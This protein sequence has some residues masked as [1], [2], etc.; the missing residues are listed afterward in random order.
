MGLFSPKKIISVASSVYNMAGE[1]KDRPQYLQSLFVRNILSETKDTI[2]QTINN[3]YATNSPGLKLRQFFKW[4][5]RKPETYNKIGIPNGV[6]T[7]GN[8]IDP[9]EL[10]PYIPHSP[11]QEVWVQS[12]SIGN[13]DPTY[14]AEQWIFINRPADIDTNWV[15]EYFKDS[16]TITIRFVDTSIVSIPATGF[17]YEAKYIYAYYMLVSS[18]TQG[19]IVPGSLVHIGE[20]PF[21][22]TTEWSL[23]SSTFAPITVTLETTTVISTHTLKHYSDGRPDEST[24]VDGPP[25]TSTSSTSYDKGEQV[26]SN[27]IYYGGDADLTTENQWMYQFQDASV[28]MTPTSTSAPPVITTEVVD[29]VTITTTV[30]VTTNVETDHIVYDRSYRIDTQTVVNKSYTDMQLMIYQIGSGNAA[31][32][33]LV[34]VVGQYEEFYP[35]IPIRLKSDWL[36]EVNPE[37]YEQARKA[38]KKATGSKIESLIEDLK[39]NE[40]I[41]DIDNIYTVFGVALNVEEEASRRYVYA[42]FEK[43]QISQ[44]G[45]PLAY[46]VFKAKYQNTIN[47]AQ[48]WY[49]WKARNRFDHGGHDEGQDSDPEPPRFHYPEPPVNEIRVK[50][51]SSFDSQ[52]DIR[53]EWAFISN[54]TGTGQGQP[55]AKANDCWIQYMGED[56]FVKVIYLN[57]SAPADH[58]YTYEK[59]RIYW[60]RSANTFTWLEIV[61][62]KHRN[63]VYGG[64][65]VSISAKEALEDS[66][67]SGFIIPLHYQT[68]WETS[69]IDRS[70]MATACVFIVFNSYEVK[71]QKWYEMGIFRILFVIVIAIAAVVFTGGAGFGLLGAHMSIGSALGLSGMTAAIVGSVI[72]AMAALI[73]S[74]LLQKLTENLGIIGAIVSAVI[75]FAIGQI[76]ASLQQSGTVTI[77]WGNFLKADNLLKLTNAVGKGV[78]GAMQANAQSTIQAAQDYARQT[79]EEISKIQEASK[80]TFGYA[81]AVIDPGSMMSTTEVMIAEGP[82]TFL[83]RTLLTGSDIAEMSH[84]MLS[85]FSQYSTTLPSAFV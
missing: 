42:F 69:V 75:M 64:K 19:P 30:T 37:A 4:V 26:Y 71:K 28:E 45:G 2:T 23:E 83:T 22:D 24:T 41:A 36:D 73:V 76:S 55:G 85:E 43:L 57:S 63:Y 48:V 54:G 59:I 56:E 67:E 78:A 62:A 74:T 60:Q 39:D 47:A 11:G 27:S 72:N 16:N 32:D 3:G 68:Y 15:C 18:D 84:D 80:A 6:M 9:E 12:G 50:S 81:G 70:Q 13:A 5:T 79:Q 31:L 7:T 34:N 77:N 25:S 14:W 82:D 61:G 53:I 8:P 35:F 21:P 10:A 58:D 65:D 29:G 46:S 40:D 1:E 49:E 52:Y 66:D 33:S 20:D 38:Y 17:N 44:I 51:D